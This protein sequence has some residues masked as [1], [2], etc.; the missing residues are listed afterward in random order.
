VSGGL[1]SDGQ[2]ELVAEERRRL[3][4]LRT[5]LVRLG[6]SAEDEARLDRA[7]RQLDEP[8]LLVVVGE[9]NSGKSTFINALL[10]ESLLEEGVTPTTRSIQVLQH[11]DCPDPAPEAGIEVVRAR[12]DW[13]RDVRVVDTPGTN[14]IQRHHE[15]LTRSFVPRSDLVLFVTSA[16]RPFTESERAF[17]E[18]I[19]EWGKKVAVVVNKID[20]LESES[21]V[22]QVVSF[23]AEAARSLLGVEPRILPAAARPAL[24]AQ[25]EGSGS[26]PGRFEAVRRFVRESLEQRERMRLKLMNPIGI[27]RR[28]AE[29]HTR[30]AAA[31]LALLAEDRA[32]VEDVE[33]QLAAWRQDLGRDFRFRLADVDNALQEFENRGMRFFDETLR[34]GRVFD[35]MNAERIRGEFERRAV[36]DTPQRIDERVSEIIDWLVAADLKQWRGISE[37]LDRRRAVHGGK[38]PGPLAAELEGERARLLETVGRAARSTVDEYDREAE[39]ARLAESV[40]SAV[41]GAALLGA[42]AVGL[43]T[44]VSLL[45]SSTAVDVTGLMAAGSMAVLGLFVIPARRARAKSELRARIASLRTRLMDALTAQFEREMDRSGQR[46]R[47]SIAPY[48]R[49]VRSEGERLEGLRKALEEH[50]A[51]LEALARRVEAEL[52]PGQVSQS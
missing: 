25:L 20:I 9:F 28:L 49:F 4:E 30:A 51:G 23:V 14:A 34:L 7:L 37:R 6:A 18:S 26:L 35:L 47:E 22:E 31:A 32:A 5:D 3:G 17:L 46:I 38:I 1:L 10:G 44:A 11:Q 16:D 24:R 12:S 2:R 43:G 45:A 8:F 39:A 41:A 50:A 48:T 52:G 15:T 13:L 42:G 33:R 36:A 29:S 27:G 40:R 21:D 19:R